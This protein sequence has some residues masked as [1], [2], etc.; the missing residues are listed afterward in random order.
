MTVPDL[1]TARLRLRGLQAT[2][3]GAVTRI[4]A[5]PATSRFLAADLSDPD[6]C[7]ASIAQRLAYT[8]PDGTGHW[9]IERDGA[10]IGLAHLR[11]STEL[12][13]DLVE[14][15]YF[16]DPA[17]GGQGLATEAADALLRHAFTTLGLPAVW[18]LVHESNVASQNLVRR[19]GFTDVGG[20]RHYGAPHRVFVALPAT[21]GHWHH[22]EVWVPDLAR[23][24][25]SFGWLLTELGWREHQRWR[26]GVSWK[27]GPG[28]LVIEQSPALTGT[29]HDR[30]APGLNHLALHAGPP[31]HVDELATAALEHGW[32]PL[33]ADR[34][35]HAGG[36][37]HHAAYLENADNFE[38]ELVADPPH[39]TQP[40]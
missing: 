8:G 34:Y 19:L 37:D 5:D 7:R 26:D 3:T 36:P 9:I 23:A 12:P 2:D 32:R 39:V 31:E 24:E 6:R 30:C 40:G 11:P 22:V 1:R 4:F 38:V 20:G 17:H 18:A 21:Q 29:V 14:I 10:V 33:F 13:G 16:L 35:P 28:Y 27:L 25:E 15:G